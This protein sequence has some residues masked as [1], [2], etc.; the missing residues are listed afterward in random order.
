MHRLVLIAVLL[1]PMPAL[2]ADVVI[3]EFQSNP[4]GSDGDA[5]WVELHNVSI[6]SVDVSGWKLERATQPGGYATVFEVPAATSIPAGGFLLLAGPSAVVPG[7]AVVVTQSND[8]GNASSSNSDGIRLV[9]D[10]GG[11]QDVVIYGGAN[12]GTQIF[13][14]ESGLDVLDVRLAPHPGSGE[15][16]ARMPD[17]EDNDDGSD[18]V[19]LSSP[20]PGQSNDAMDTDPGDTDDTDVPV[21]CPAPGAVVINEL[22][23]NPSGTDGDAE[24][25]ELVVTGASPVD[26]SGWTVEAALS[27]GS[28]DPAFTIPASTTLSPGDFLVLAG[29]SATGMPLDAIIQTQGDTFGNAS[30]SSDAAALF[31]A[32]GC[33][34]DL[35]AYGVANDP[36]QV[37]DD[38]DG[39]PIPDANLAP[40]GPDSGSIG[41]HPDGADT[42][43]GAD[44]FNVYATPSPGTANPAPSVTPGPGGDCAAPVVLLINEFTVNVPGTD[45]NAEWVE[46]GNPTSQTVDLEG[47][48]VQ[49]A[50]SPG[51]WDA[52]LV[53]PAGVSIP[54][55][56]HVVIGGELADL[57]D[58]DNVVLV[59]QLSAFGNASSTSDAVRLLDAGGCVADVVAYGGQNDTIESD[60]D[61]DAGPMEDAFLDEDGT[62]MLNGRLAPVGGD[63]SSIARV[64]DLEDSN[65]P[66]QDFVVAE[67]PSPGEANPDLSCK[68]FA[69]DIVINE[70]RANPA[71]T[72][73]EAGSEFVELY[74]PTGGDLDVSGW[75]IRE[76]GTTSE[77]VAYTF[78]PG[79]IVPAGGYR[80]AGGPFAEVV[81]DVVEDMDLGSG[82]GGD[83]VLLYDCE[84]ERADAILYGGV[85]EDGLQDDNGLTPDQGAPKPPDD[86][87]LGRRPDGT[88]TNVSADDITLLPTCTP[89]ET[90]GE[91]SSSGGG[92]GG[93]DGPG[94]CSC[95]GGPADPGVPEIDSPEAR[96]PGEGCSTVPSGRFGALLAL[97]VVVGLRRR[98]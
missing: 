72:D 40:R 71:G 31:D 20:T 91:P 66:G 64:V 24:W 46:V 57:P 68:A 34:V 38:E 18:F 97:G 58:E 60:T 85:N 11:V 69:G 79:S 42:N 16:T 87:C 63:T 33:L 50:S 3:N 23:T 10:L 45:D 26:V 73:S 90:N 67:E 5:E 93:P 49:E 8:M 96:E 83:L 30:S 52:A 54:A 29:N 41:R 44:D 94:G 88:D 74:N 70:F 22:S 47:W 84:D 59:T 17:G 2:A 86:R 27:P 1:T 53:F 6:G 28:F 37:F 12:N 95:G 19:V 82:S 51:S 21:V 77:S 55:G 92:G 15:S 61:T 35:V 80:V 36:Q 75:T 4:D 56:G 48:Q 9:D 7:G 76:L 98:R 62:P 25:V 89:G 65:D 78:R 13:V 32:E 39:Q 43:V 81:D 14:D